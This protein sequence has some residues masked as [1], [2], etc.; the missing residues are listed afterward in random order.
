MLGEFSF[1]AMSQ[2]GWKGEFF[3][4]L[5]LLICMVLMVNLLIALLSTTYSRLAS[6]GVGLYLQNIIEE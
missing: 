2:E 4:A 6:Q 5:Y 1:D 3:L